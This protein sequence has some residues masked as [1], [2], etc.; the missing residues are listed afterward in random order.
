MEL[1]G[2]LEKQ[3]E[4]GF[5]PVPW[6]TEGPLTRSGSP[7]ATEGEH[8]QQGGELQAE[9]SGEDKK[10]TEKMEAKPGIFFL[11]GKSHNSIIKEE[12]MFGRMP[13]LFSDEVEAAIKNKKSN[14]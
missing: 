6:W 3:I 10:L 4:P 12:D 2:T 14:V 8:P 5:S 9:L 7:G 1:E 11:Q 13:I